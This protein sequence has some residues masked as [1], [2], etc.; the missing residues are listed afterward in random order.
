MAASIA[1]G[2]GGKDLF[3]GHERERSRHRFVPVAAFFYC[4]SAGRRPIADGITSTTRTVSRPQRRA[5]TRSLCDLNPV[6][7]WG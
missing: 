1:L 5:L 2:C 3:R 7:E 4:P 6:R